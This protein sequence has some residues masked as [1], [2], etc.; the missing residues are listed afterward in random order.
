MWKKINLTIDEAAKYS[1]I[2]KNKIR[3]LIK[4][5][6]CDFIL[7]VGT[8]TLIKRV[9]FESYLALRNLL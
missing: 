6:D 8:K 5:K 1:N 3:E 4:E 2:G 7:Q 9:K